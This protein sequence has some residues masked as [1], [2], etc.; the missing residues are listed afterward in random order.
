MEC[1]HCNVSIGGQRVNIP[2]LWGW[3]PQ[4]VN[5]SPLSV[6]LG[7]LLSLQINHVQAV[8]AANTP[9]SKQLNIAKKSPPLPPPKLSVGS[10]TGTLHF[11]DR[12]TTYLGLTLNYL[13]CKY[14]ACKTKWRHYL[15]GLTLHCPQ[16]IY[17]SRSPEA[18]GQQI[19]LELQKVYKL[20][21]VKIKQWLI[22]GAHDTLGDPA[23]SWTWGR[24]WWGCG[25]L[26]AWELWGH[27]CTS[28]A[29]KILKKIDWQLSVI[30]L[31]KHT[32]MIDRSV[33]SQW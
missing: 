5:L 10:L 26:Q 25:R 13:Q 4:G 24:G 22:Q 32:G 30:S 31:A 15:G 3:W 19:F 23:T 17:T 7:L 16:V 33:Q 8:T 14:E 29:R 18:T 2:Q 20:K 21:G 27:N 11:R 12:G 6:G 1:I 28:S 9:A